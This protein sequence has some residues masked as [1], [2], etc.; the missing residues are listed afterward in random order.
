VRPKLVL[1]DNIA[2]AA[3]FIETGA[4][5][6]GL[7]A[8]SLVLSPALRGRGAYTRV[9]AAWHSPLEQAFVLTRRAKDNPLAD[10]FANHLESPAARSTLRGHGFALP[11]E[12]E[13]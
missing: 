4:A 9:P 12:A 7:I 8:L 11:G 2:Q 5:Q 13:R 10:A 3:Q 1:G 6:A